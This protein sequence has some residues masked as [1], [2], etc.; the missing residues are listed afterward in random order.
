MTSSSGCP[1]NCGCAGCRTGT[2]L[3]TPAAVFNPPGQSALT[4]RVGTHGQFLSSLRARLSSPA[5]PALSKLTVRSTDDPA[6]A[7]LDAWAVLGDLLSFYSERIADE[8]YL[9]TATQNASIQMLGGLVGYRPRPGVAGGTAL[10]FTIDPP[11]NPGGDTVALL[12]AGTRAQSVPIPGHDSQYFEIGDNL[13]ARSSLNQLSVLTRLP[14]QLTAAEAQ[15]RA[16]IFL[17]GTANN[18]KAGDQLLFV[19]SSD[20]AAQNQRILLQ[21]PGV[22][23]DQANAITV[24]GLPGPAQPNLKDLT[25]ELQN[26]LGLVSEPPSPAPV[27][28]VPPFSALA[29]RFDAEVLQATLNPTGGFTSPADLAAACEQVRQRAV[30]TLVLAQQYPKVSDWLRA[31]VDELAGLRD[32][33]LALEPPQPASSGTGQG[34]GDP[35][36]AGLAGIFAALHTT[37]NPPPPSARD[38]PLDPRS[39]YAIG[40]DLGPQLLAALDPQVSSGLYQAWQHTSV[41]APSALQQLQAMRVVATPF[42]ATAPLVANLDPHSGQVNGYTDWPLAG[43]K[44]ISLLL[45]YDAS[46]GT[47]QKQADFTYL[48]GGP[49]TA[50]LDLPTATT[51]RQVGPMSVTVTSY[52]TPGQTPPHTPTAPAAPSAPTQ[53]PATSEAPTASAHESAAWHLHLPGHHE[54]AA[55]QTP[56]QTTVQTT[57]QTA[58]AQTSGQGSG[59][60]SGPTPDAAPAPAHEAGLL[61]AYQDQFDGWTVFVGLPVE[62]DGTTVGADGKVHVLVTSGQ[63]SDTKEFQ[64][65]PGDKPATSL[66]D[67][68]SVAASRAAS[69]A[70]TQTVSVALTTPSSTPSKNRIWLD[71]TYDGI[72]VGSWVVID[73]PSKQAAAA[74]AA[75]LVAAAGP[76]GQVSRAV[77]AMSAAAMRPDPAGTSLARVITRVTAVRVQAR[78]DF[79]IAGKVTQLDLDDDWLDDTDVNLAQI[80]DTTVYAR[81]EALALATEPVPDDVQGSK[82]E[83]AQL[84]TGITPGRLIAVSGERTDI[85]NTPGV[86]GAE[87]AMVAG[88]DQTVDPSLPGD[89]VRT[90]LTL[91]SA[92][93]YTYKR[94]TVQI[95]G[96]VA[97]A[98]QGASRDDPIGS[99]N[100]GTPNQTFKLW[101]A[102]LTWLPAGTTPSGAASTLQVRVN[103]VLWTEVDSF[104][105]HGPAER[106]YTTSTAS[107]GKTVVTFGDGVTG[108]RLPTGTENVRARYRVGLG[109]SGDV[110]AG[111]VTQLTTRPLGVSAV[112][113]PVAG[114][115]GADPDP[116]ELA[117]SNI[118]LALTAL[119]RL[120]SVPDYEDFARSYAGIGRAGAQRLSDGARQVVHVTVAGVDDSP[121]LPDN[122]LLASLHAALSEF[123]DPQLP[124]D[125]AVRELVLLIVALSVKLTPDA[126]WDLVEPVLRSTL[127]NLLSVSNRQL[128]QPAYASEVIAAAQAVPGVDYVDLQAF[129]GVPGS[130][131][132]L[133]LISLFTNLA[134]PSTSVPS[135]LAAFDETRHTVAADTGVVE[136]LGQIAAEYAISVDALLALNPGLR[137]VVL[138]VG[139]SIVV[140]RG[141]RPAQL[142]VLSASVP[143]T[144]ILREITS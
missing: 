25:S 127:T 40:S 100:A 142:V 5:Y 90:T 118:P 74:L 111:Q 11:Q 124:V 1:T 30:E 26:C 51:T 32:R 123:G 52:P 72:A 87:L 6:I 37:P 55:A 49:N 34:S 126:A 101:Q 134:N 109:R 17:S 85:P 9:R 2:A 82:I 129:T 63:S 92:L 122:G 7:L 95:Y 39:L 56:A 119:D 141:I 67:G 135:A 133:G 96:N 132:P 110:E 4:F 79:G 35:A 105:G 77:S 57:L 61:V 108:A 97:A 33:G 50:T 106:I 59:Q 18:V 91:A 130:T 75:G 71:S 47:V 137:D 62:D 58:A 78:A 15:K 81:G 83:L 20:K 89:T 73:R 94:A 23:I 88:V 76:T 80:R 3:E 114:T 144:L 12:P 28:K 103:G 60:G 13:T 22:T 16:Q 14:Y 36:L 45:S 53:T 21:V 140:F 117:R 29:A 121:L 128:G 102:P 113:N 41:S 98:T 143:D 139:D 84:Y 44:E 115:G 64:L 38:L 104:A 86:T 112:T 54:A 138:T 107:D 19:F 42:G 48:E 131:T 93:A 116:P 99:G 10:A 66:L 70:S 69:G 8:G 24:V 31:W 136:T 65:A 27:P 125:V 68:I 43:T 120:V 46:T